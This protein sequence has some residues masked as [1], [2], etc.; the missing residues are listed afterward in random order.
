MAVIRAMLRFVSTV[1]LLALLA[2]AGVAQEELKIGGIGS[3]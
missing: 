1:A 2:T 3:R